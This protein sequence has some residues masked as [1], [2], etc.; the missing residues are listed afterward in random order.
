[1][2][3]IQL[4]P[5]FSGP[6]RVRVRMAKEVD[7]QWYENAEIEKQ[8]DNIHDQK[9]DSLEVIYNDYSGNLEM[10]ESNT[11]WIRSNMFY[12]DVSDFR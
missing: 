10:A 8:I 12:M 4:R 11:E 7:W 6:S 9:D 2:H 5:I 1:M 3:P